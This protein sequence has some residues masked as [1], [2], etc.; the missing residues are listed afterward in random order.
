VSP[1]TL[2]TGAQ[3]KQRHQPTLPQGTRAWVVVAGGRSVPSH[4]PRSTDRQTTTGTKSLNSSTL[5]GIGE[6]VV[7]KSGRGEQ[8]TITTTDK[9]SSALGATSCETGQN[10]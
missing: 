5:R 1:V 10:L 8:D 7:R 4:H 9:L 2:R 3:G 6:G